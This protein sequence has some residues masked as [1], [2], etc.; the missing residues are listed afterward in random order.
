MPGVTTRKQNTHTNR[1]KRRRRLSNSPIVSG[2]VKTSAQE[3]I[4][5]PDTGDANEHAHITWYTG[6]NTRYTC[7]V[8]TEVKPKRGRKDKTTRFHVQFFRNTREREQYWK[9]TGRDWDEKARFFRFKRKVLID[10]DGQWWVESPS[11]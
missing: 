7:G 9:G 1:S 10:S 2:M 3:Q 4:P 5:L 11:S 8:L 6:K